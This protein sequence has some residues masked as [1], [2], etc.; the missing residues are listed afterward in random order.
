MI[1]RHPLRKNLDETPVRVRRG[2]GTKDKAVAEERLAEMNQLL[3]DTSFWNPQAKGRAAT[4]FCQIVVNAFYD[5][6]FPE[7]RNPWALRDVI[8]LQKGCPGVSQRVKISVAPRLIP[9][10]DA[11]ALRVHF[12]P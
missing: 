9:I 5:D 8:P 6:L 3:S 7:A 1:F 12:Q 4:M 10:R 11:V 2:L